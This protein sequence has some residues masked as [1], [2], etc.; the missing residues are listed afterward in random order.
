ME[1]P[2]Q[3]VRSRKRTEQEARLAP[4]LRWSLRDPVPEGLTDVTGIARAALSSLEQ[5]IVELDATALVSALSAGHYTAVHVAE[6]FFH[7]TVV[8]HQLTNC[9][10]E[11][12]FEE[13]L[14]RAAELDRH[15]QATGQ[16]VGPL[17]GKQACHRCLL[18][19]SIHIG[20]RSAGK[21]QRSYQG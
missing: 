14:A 19:T 11:I 18:M 16:L 15:F 6:A 21:H 7:A 9:L 1:H 12:F 10:T 4:F 13:G 3:D 20:S 8:A 2:S 17:H 5:E